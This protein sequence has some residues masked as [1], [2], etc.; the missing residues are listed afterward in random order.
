MENND[1]DHLLQSIIKIFGTLASPLEQQMLDMQ[2]QLS[3]QNFLLELLYANSFLHNAEGFDTFMHGA[4]DMTRSKAVRT[5]PMSEEQA[6]EM[7][8]RIATRLQRFHESVA[9]R[10]SQ[11]PRG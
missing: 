2:A 4:L 3:A 6:L 7:H 10:I 5:G 1:E 8:A 11:G 9:L